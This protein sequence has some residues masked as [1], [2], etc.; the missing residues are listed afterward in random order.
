MADVKVIKASRERQIQAGRAIDKIRVA[1]YCRVSTDSEDQMNS[2]HSQVKYYTELIAKNHNWQMVDVY[3]DAA[4]TGTKVDKREGFRRMIAD[5]LEGRIDQVITK[6]I[7]RFAR[8]T[9]DTLKYVRMLKEKNIAVIFEDEKINT[10]TMDGELLLTVLSSVAQQEVENISANVKKGLKMKMQRG[11][12]IGFNGCYGY[13]YDPVTKGI[14]VNEEERPYVEYIFDRYIQGAGCKTIARELKEKGV[15]K[16]DGTTEWKESGIRGIIEN[17]K[18][19]GDLLMGAT[20]TADPI[21]KRRLRNFGEEDMFYVQDHHE[22]IISREQFDLAQKIKEI[23]AGNRVDGRHK[24]AYKQYAFSGVIRCGCCGAKYARKTIHGNREEYRRIMWQCLNYVREGKKSCPKCKA[25]REEILEGAFVEAYKVLCQQNE[26]L[27][28]RAIDET[29]AMLGTDDI[30]AKVRDLKAKVAHNNERRN[31]LLDRMLTSSVSEEAFEKK[32]SLID[33]EIS[34]LNTRIRYLEDES[35][36]RENRKKQLKSLQRELK[37]GEVISEFNRNVFE[38]IVQDVIVGGYDKSGNFQPY[39]ITFILKT[40]ERIELDGKDYV[41]QRKNAAAY[42]RYD[43]SCFRIKELF[44]FTYF[45]RYFKFEKVKSG[46]RK[47]QLEEVNVT[48]AIP[49]YSEVWVESLKK[50][51]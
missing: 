50:A 12:L 6:S 33:S 24:L 37:I 41:P 43:E 25:I 11:E 19:K 35:R 7:S 36:V 23:R 51:G 9:V 21:S 16:R 34:N 4:I 15:L 13:D 28:D 47:V 32:L 39:N 31:H 29:F 42:M 26:N 48:V 46:M 10:L 22:P 8:N 18:Y 2:Y 5:C 14:S 49:D 3:T 1:A 20:F 27:V 44:H 38:S 17:V 45:S 30:D 40:E